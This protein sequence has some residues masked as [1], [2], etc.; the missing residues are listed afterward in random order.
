MIAVIFLAVF[1]GVFTSVYASFV[2]E[3][4][5]VLLAIPFFILMALAFFYARETLLCS[6]ILFRAAI[7]NLLDLTKFGQF[8]LGAFINA[9]LILI[10]INEIAKRSQHAKRILTIT[11][12]PF[13]VIS[14]ITLFIAPNFI[15]A[16]KVYLSLVSYASIFGLGLVMIT[17]EGEYSQWMNLVLL[18]SII[19]VFYGFVDMANGGYQSANGFRV[20]STFSHPNTFA[21]YLVNMISLF[22]ISMKSNVSLFPIWVRTKIPAYIFMM[23]ILLLMTK[24]RSAWISCVMFFIVYAIVYERKYFI[25][26]GLCL[27]LAIMIPG[28]QDRILDL[29]Q[30]NEVINYSRLNSYAWRKLVWQEG[31]NWMTPRHYFF[32]Y[33]LEAFK[34]ESKNFFIMPF[35]IK[36][37]ANTE[38]GGHS[39]YVQLFFEIGAIGLLAFLWIYIKVAKLLIPFYKK[40]KLRVF[41]SMMFLLEYLTYAYSDN[42]LEILS[43]NWYLWFV[44]GAIYAVNYSRQNS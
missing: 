10:A 18:S 16:I 11:W 41:L 13:L 31:L 20:N 27:F 5:G 32:G 37:D 6:I 2:G 40:D 14:S 19:P 42:M 1:F 12:L 15:S 26:L 29:G 4:F 24:T 8:G 43:F 44:L 25:Y 28:V 36:P 39:V 34:F 38:V 3:H 33:G 22:F 9:L 7:D 30:G 35:Q 21:F 23:I 17:N